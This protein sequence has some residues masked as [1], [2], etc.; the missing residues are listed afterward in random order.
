MKMPSIAQPFAE[1][2]GA[3]PP[4]KRRKTSPAFSIRFTDD[5]RARLRRDAGKLSL[6]AHVRRKLFADDPPSPPRNT[7]KAR[8]IY[9]EVELLAKLL[10]TLGQSDLHDGLGRLSRAAESGALPVTPEL[11]ERLAATCLLVEVIRRDL[12]AA[13]GVK[14]PAHS[15]ASETS[16]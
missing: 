4:R 15:A 10:A 13:L 5:E 7:R 16:R 2:T 8:S 1:Q 12:V 6:A 3:K 9:V 14:A 11:E